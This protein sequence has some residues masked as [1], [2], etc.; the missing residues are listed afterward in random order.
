[1]DANQDKSSR[2]SQ[3]MWVMHPFAPLPRHF[4]HFFFF[5]HGP[6]ERQARRLGHQNL[7]GLPCKCAAQ[8]LQPQ[9]CPRRAAV[10][11]STRPRS[12]APGYGGGG[13]FVS[14]AGRFQPALPI[15][16]AC[17]TF[18][19]TPSSQTVLTGGWGSRI[20]LRQ[21]PERSGGRLKLSS[22]VVGVP[23][24]SRSPRGLGVGMMPI[25]SSRHPEQ[26]SDQKKRL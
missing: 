15:R 13:G 1:M 19:F 23:P 25:G 24:R 26:E 16:D 11:P 4:R 2:E 18:Q 5:V 8:W 9:I 14:S 10:Q 21:P 7:R 20:R 12:R 22:R 17:W 6:V 3:V